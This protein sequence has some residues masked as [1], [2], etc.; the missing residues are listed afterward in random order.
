MRD[1]GKMERAFGKLIA[2]KDGRPWLK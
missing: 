1:D 2:G